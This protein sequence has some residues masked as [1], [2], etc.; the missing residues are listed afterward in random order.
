MEQ[1]IILYTIWSLIII[2]TISIPFKFILIMRRFLLII[3][4]TW[5]KTLRKVKKFNFK[6]K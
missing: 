6:H 3:F 5:N 4:E 2:F 1:T